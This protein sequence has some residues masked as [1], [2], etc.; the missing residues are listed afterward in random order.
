MNGVVIKGDKAAHAK[1]LSGLIKQQPQILQ[2]PEVPVGASPALAIK[3]Q[4]VSAATGPPSRSL[5]EVG[6]APV[7][8]A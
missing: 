2:L 3:Y 8:Q 5:S 6:A 4:P 7:L 1:E